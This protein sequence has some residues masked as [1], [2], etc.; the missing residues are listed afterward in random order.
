LKNILI[1]GGTGLFG[2]NFYKQFHQKYNIFLIGNRKRK[3]FNTKIYYTDLFDTK[4]VVFFCKKNKIDTI[5]HAAAMTSIEDCQKYKKK[6]FKIN[7]ILTKL[8]NKLCSM[9]KIKFIFISTDQVFNKNKSFKGELLKSNPCNYYGYTKSA[10]EKAVLNDNLD[11][12]VIRTN[13]FGY[14]T[15]YRKSFSDW[16]IFNI[17]KNIKINVFDD[18]YFNPLYLKNLNIYLINL[19]KLKSKGIFNL[20]S[21][22]KIS[23]FEFAIKIA[24]AFKL[25]NKFI[26]KSKFLLNKNLVKRPRDMTLSNK[27]LKKK[28][29]LKNINIQKQIKNMLKDDKHIV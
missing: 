9:K 23:K 5:I 21:D 29:G 18:I 19:I 22:E 1:T 4:K 10:A 13:F 28:L 14:G 2:L 12:L 3:I 11:S 17:K 26:I 15:K 7:V 6:C 25:N 16:I 20:V 24:S 8:L 27:K